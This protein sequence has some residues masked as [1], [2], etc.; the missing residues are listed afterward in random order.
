[1]AY[2]QHRDIEVSGFYPAFTGKLSLLSCSLEMEEPFDFSVKTAIIYG[3][4]QTCELQHV[5][6]SVLDK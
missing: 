1:M 4:K 2:Q 6:L 5:F 3:N